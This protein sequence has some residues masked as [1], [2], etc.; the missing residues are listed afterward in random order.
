MK[1]YT[2]K[3]LAWVVGL[4]CLVVLTARVAENRAEAAIGKGQQIIVERG[5]QIQGMITKDNG[6]DL[7]AYQNAKYNT[8]NWLWETPG[9]GPPA[10]FPWAR[11]VG[12]ETKMPAGAELAQ[13]NELVSLQLGDEW[14]LNNSSVR[15]RA[16]NWFN[17]IRSQ[18]PNTILYMN[19][20]G[21]QVNDAALADFVSRAQPDM[22]SFDA[23]PFQADPIT[24]VPNGPGYGS[25]TSWYGELRRY[26][27][28]A[29]NAGVPLS[30]Y[31][32]TFHAIEGTTREYRDPSPSE[33]NLNTFG[34][35]AFGA[36]T[37][38]DFTYN[39][40]ASMVAP[41]GIPQQPGFAQ[42]TIVNQRARNLGKALVHLTGKDNPLNGTLSGGPATLDI[43]FHRG[44]TGPNA[45]DVTPLPI[46]FQPDGGAPNTFSEWVSDRNDPFM[47]GW[48]V[49][50][51]GVNCGTTD[52]GTKNNGLRGDV[53][54]SWMKP[55]DAAVDDPNDPIDQLYFMVVNSFTGPDGTAADYRQRIQINFLGTVGPTI[56]QLNPD[57][58]QVEFVNLDIIPNSGGRRKLVVELD[59][60]MG[61]LFKFNTGHAF[62]GT[63]MALSGDYN[64]DGKVDAA[65]YVVWR[66]NNGT[67]YNATA[68]N[69]WKAN[70]GKTLAGSGAAARISVPEP[71]L[72][73]L[74][75][76]G[77]TALLLPGRVQRFE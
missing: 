57:T 50:N 12:D 68:Y 8:T 13:L 24:H 69:T 19:N 55:L 56:Q 1:K 9:A 72:W 29:E 35:L 41:Q 62:L 64:N 74:M 16:V 25:P 33:M 4:Q 52:V 73:P 17:A 26:R 36:T 58:G 75:A 53:I 71:G 11:W 38:I 6:F 14:D 43:M 49:T 37:F 31:R 7:S 76:I 10:G 15:D 63:S 46:G 48:V 3:R 21:G 23:Y 2:T 61:A 59:G 28:Y 65:D 22:L 44:K 30:I 27:V 77:A 5:L 51:C 70:L 34:A 40:G 60:G 32:Q 39:T 66:K 67:I 18:W 20:W 54:F 42:Q 45:A 47:R